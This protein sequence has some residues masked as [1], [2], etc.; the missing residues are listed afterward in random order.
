MPGPDL[1]VTDPVFEWAGRTPYETAII[2]C[3]R[4]V[5]YRT[6]CTAVLR[7][8]A[9]FREAGWQPGQVI[10]VSLQGDAALQL[11]V[12]LALARAGL[13]Q[14]WL[15]LGDPLEY[16]TARAQALRVAAVVTDDE[17]G[18]LKSIAHL[19]PDPG[20]LATSG[21]APVPPDLRV[22]GAGRAMI[23][24]QS[25]G[26]TGVPKDIVVSHD[27]EM[28]FADR[29]KPLFACLPGERF[30]NLTAVRFWTGLTRA[31]RCLS[32][33]GTF[34]VPPATWTP[35]ELLQCIELHHV[36]YFAC[37][38][39][40]MRLLLDGIGG[41]APRL[42]GLRILRCSS[43]AL[44]VSVLQEVRRRIS[45][46]L[47]VNYGANEAGGITAAPPALLDRYP[48]CAGFPL[49]G[50]DLEIVDE[51]DRPVA[52][53]ELGQVRIR[54]AGIGPRRMLGAAPEAAPAFK[55]DWY[56]PGDIGVRNAEGVVFLKGRSD[57]V[58]NFDGIMVGPAEIES[59]LSRH[60]AV[61]EAAAF[62]LPS[63][64]HQDIP[65]VAVVLRYY[66]PIEELTLYCKQHL[67]I[68]APREFVLIDA[69]PRSPIGKILR[70]RLTELAVARI[71]A[72]TAPARDAG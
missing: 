11:V 5:D 44:P 23:L 41:D 30:M 47:Y 40:H 46:N 56:Y 20:W 29:F 2:E 48:D 19:A 65:A 8:M 22:N 27:E 7:A 4:V 67:G 58:M 17:Q 61:A 42:P 16:R 32:T 26:T 25:S 71:N 34:I 51:N 62:P 15:P 3:D 49:E 72:G 28:L 54:G 18:A 33:G 50:I 9:A 21:T 36:T 45:P 59:V 13:A 68:R 63:P 14:V 66:V 52:A 55:G 24:I 70:R 43:A 35:E 6:L 31:L 1:N 64:L 57:E 69:I 39:M 12:S 53:G 38:P 10:A 37:A 60:P